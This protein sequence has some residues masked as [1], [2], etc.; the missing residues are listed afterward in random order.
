M[1]TLVQYPWHFEWSVTDTANFANLAEV[2]CN[3]FKTPPLLRDTLKEI[4]RS[5][6]GALNRV[7]KRAAKFA[8]NMNELGWENLAQRRLID[9]ICFLFKNNRERK[10]II[11]IIIIIIIVSPHGLEYV[12][13]TLV[14]V[15]AF[16]RFQP[17]KTRSLS[18][19]ECSLR[20]CRAIFSPPVC[21]LNSSLWCK[22][23]LL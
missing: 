20:I 2:F 19:L 1:K 22:K 10:V 9:R 13:M 17:A 18:A 3:R 7:Q 14:N 15:L 11:I 5:K 16:Y 6:G 21:P 12:A 23:A 4:S 8:N